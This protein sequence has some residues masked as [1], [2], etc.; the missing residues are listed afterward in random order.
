MAAQVLTAELADELAAQFR[1]TLL[2]PGDDDYDEARKVWNGMID[3]RPAMIAR[4]AGAADVIAAVRFARDTALPVAVRSGGHSASGHSVCDDGLVIDLSAMRSIRVDPEA[5]TARAEAGATWGD[6]DAETQA[7]GLAVTGG[8]YS[9]TGIAGLTLGSGSGWLERRCG[10]TPDNLIAADIVLADGRLVT[11]SE[12][13][14]PELFWGIRGGGGNFGIVTSF[15][16]N[17]HEIGP[18]IYGGML[19]AAP[20]RAGEILRFL[21]AFMP[22]APDDLGLAFAF[23]SAPPEPH[24][25]A[26]FHFAPIAGVVVCWSG[27]HD[28]GEAVL[29]PLREVV[30]PL[31]D[32][33]GPMPYTALQSMLDNGGPYGT[34]AY[35]KAEFLPELSDAAIAKLARHGAARPGPMC[36]LLLEPMG[37]AIERMDPD[38][39]ALGRRD[40]PWC[41]HALGLWMEDD[42]A[43]DAA[44]VAWATDL[45]ADLAPDTTSGVYL[46]YTSDEG[47]ERVRATYG[48]KYARLVA[49]KDRY[50]PANMFRLNQNIR[51]S[52]MVSGP[53]A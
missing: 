41:Y 5:R 6:F 45:A 44:H 18:M 25:P 11:A 37:G 31:M 12:D 20:D 35:M 26:E 33:V 28:E 4:C 19:V 21:R 49:L 9:T 8:R 50:D 32:M 27:P 47:E 39:T 53:G 16:Y 29:A 2:R 42:P 23:V 14:H 51:P 30:Q 38:A 7:F 34:R 22:T 17:L 1:G 3:R 36:A 13:S 10:L 24:V 46:N 15:V 52:A 40:V 43:T 48:E